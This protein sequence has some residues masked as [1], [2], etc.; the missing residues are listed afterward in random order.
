MFSTLS[1]GMTQTGERVN[2]YTNTSYE[3]IRR[4]LV[5]AEM[6]PA[7]VS[8]IRDWPEHAMTEYEVLIPGLDLMSIMDR[9]DLFAENMR[10][11]NRIVVNRLFAFYDDKR[12]VWVVRFRLYLLQIWEK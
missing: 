2:V 11:I 1:I 10:K 7:K 3:K 9:T 12:K 6:T 5:H 4:A 8:A